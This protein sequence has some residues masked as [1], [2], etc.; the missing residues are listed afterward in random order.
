MCFNIVSPTESNE[1]WEGHWD[2]DHFSNDVRQRIHNTAKQTIRGQVK[3]NLK[4]TKIVN[5]KLTIKFIYLT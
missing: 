2:F 1:I 3:I 5:T 4:I